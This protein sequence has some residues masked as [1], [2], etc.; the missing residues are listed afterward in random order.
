VH[1]IAVDQDG[2]VWLGTYGDGVTRFDGE[3]STPYA[4]PDGLGSRWVYAMAVAPDGVVWCGTSSGAS[5]FDGKTWTTYTRPTD[6]QTTW[7]LTLAV[8][9]DNTVWSGS[10]DGGK[11]R[12]DGKT[13]TPTAGAGPRSPSLPTARVVRIH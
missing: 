13:W 1:A 8:A 9:L 12:F 6:W 5:R 4:T 10:Y 2:D 7:W 3:I 11:S